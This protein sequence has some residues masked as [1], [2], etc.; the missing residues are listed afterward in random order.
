MSASSV[1]PVVPRVI[2]GN[3]GTGPGPLG[4]ARRP[5]PLPALS[6]EYARTADTAYALSAVDKSGRIADR[7]IVRALGWAPETRLD[8]REQSGVILAC[9]TAD[10]V[11]RI[12]NRG[13]MLL[14]LT[15]RRWCRLKA[16][17]RVLLVAHLSAD[18]L[19]AHPLTVLD[20]LLAGT[21]SAVKRGETA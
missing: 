18:V 2:P 12:G 1:P 13:Y 15:V 17:D 14:P 11:H 6:S 9:A 8:I 16:G 19:A 20:R 4:R 21:H 10:G 3:A 7:S 5:L